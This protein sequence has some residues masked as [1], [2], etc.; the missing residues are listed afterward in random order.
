MT[1]IETKQNELDAKFASMLDS[2]YGHIHAFN[3]I[4]SMFFEF[5]GRQ[6]EL[7]NP[8]QMEPKFPFRLRLQLLQSLLNKTSMLNDVGP[9]ETF[10]VCNGNDK[11]T[12]NFLGQEPFWIY[13]STIFIAKKEWS[14]IPQL[15]KMVKETLPTKQTTPLK[16]VEG[17]GWIVLQGKTSPMKRFFKHKSL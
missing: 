5:L 14:N 15:Q 8:I 1:T 17:E 11:I 10:G 3:E 16:S 2:Q 9:R 13:G 4:K 7:T 12:A 6:K